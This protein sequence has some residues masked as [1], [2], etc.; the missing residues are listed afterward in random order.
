MKNIKTLFYTLIAIIVSFSA[1]HSQ[2][3]QSG[4]M[5][6]YSEMREVLIWVQTKNESKVKIKYWVKTASGESF[7][8]DEMSSKKEN[9]FV[10]KCIANKVLPSNV[11][12]YQVFI[13]GKLE[14][15]IYPLS[16]QSKALWQFRTDA[17]D[18]KFTLGSCAFVNEERFDRPGNPYGGEYE[19]YKAIYNK[20]PDF[21]L[22]GGDNLYLREPDWDTRTGILHRYTHARSLPELQPL[23]GSTHNFAIWDDHDFG[24]NDSDRSFYNK[25]TTTE[26]FKLFWGNNAYGA[27]GL[28]GTT[29]QFSWNDADFFLLDDRY[30]RSPNNRKS[31]NC[32][33]LGEEQKQWLIDALSFSRATFKF[34]VVGSQ[35]LNSAVTKENFVNCTSERDYLLK[36]IADE[37]I[38]GVVFITGD[39]HHTEVSKLERPQYPLYDF[40]VSPL[41][42]SP[43]KGAGKETNFYRIPESLITERNFGQIEITGKKEDRKLKLTIFDV[44][45]EEKYSL[46]ILAKD[47]K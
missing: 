5:L 31:T 7:F 24:P 15:I 16:F 26:I 38:T 39:R 25:E 22:W 6:G 14:K 8:T 12:D 9:G 32:T 23:L 35:F 29:S 2:N 21:M 28:K 13:N 10:V 42:S 19:I 3:I 20:K 17:P 30:Y 47:L 44:K 40:T 27:A 4:P 18:F 37:R 11:Y 33:I 41:G 46:T 36:S 45:G 1:L 34:V 43:N